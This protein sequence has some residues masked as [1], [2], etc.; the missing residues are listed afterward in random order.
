MAI[1]FDASSGVTYVT[2]GTSASLSHTCTGSDRI[3]FVG[4]IGQITTDVISG[5]TYNSVSMTL[6]DKILCPSDRYIYLYYL[7]APATGTNNIT[8]T[9][10][11]STD[12]A[13]GG[14][15]YTGVDQTSPI[16]GTAKATATVTNSLTSTVTTTTANDWI[17][18][19]FRNDGSAMSAGTST[20]S[21][22]LTTGAGQ[23]ARNMDSNADRSSG[24][25]SL[26]ATSG[27]NANWAYVSAGFKPVGG[28]GG[29]AVK[30]QFLG[31]AR[32]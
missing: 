15:S 1:A 8:V 21:R 25:N 4:V 3:L 22:G 9:A 20:T 14:V 27:G 13:F 12:L 24:S 2:T 10:S 29:G 28:G 19:L 32:L 17:V 23:F 5:V 16:D 6:V 11:S 26:Q 7:I 31:F 18:S 30:P